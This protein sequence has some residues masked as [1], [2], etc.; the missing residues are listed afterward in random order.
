MMPYCG[1]RQKLIATHAQYLVPHSDLV[2]LT[3]SLNFISLLRLKLV[4]VLRFFIINITMNP[5]VVP[6]LIFS[7]KPRFNFWWQIQVVGDS[8]RH[9]NL[10]IL[11]R[12]LRV[13]WFLLVYISDKKLWNR[14]TI[15]I[16]DYDS[17]WMLILGFVNFLSHTHTS[18]H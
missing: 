3:N 11:I 4:F 10:E 18:V 1:Q 16:R 6:T 13:T 14:G 17:W 12:L 2:K 15:I 8:F 7:R 9:L 5:F